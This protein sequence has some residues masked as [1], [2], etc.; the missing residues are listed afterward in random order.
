MRTTVTIDDAVYDQTRRI[1][2][3]S[4]RSLGEVLNELLVAGLERSEYRQPQRVLGS[5]RGFV[6]VADDFDATPPEVLTSLEEPLP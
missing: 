6:E 1:A 3:E 5:L 4:R 2:F